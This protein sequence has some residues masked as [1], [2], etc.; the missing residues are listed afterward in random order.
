MKLQHYDRLVLTEYIKGVDVL[1]ALA[2][3]NPQNVE[4]YAIQL[5]YRH[6]GHKFFT[7]SEAVQL[8]PR[9]GIPTQ[10][11]VKLVV[12]GKRYI[13]NVRSGVIEELVNKRK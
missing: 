9:D 11:K 2:N 6:N 4:D 1:K 5:F 3:K 12:E 8:I 13:V 7:C 10:E